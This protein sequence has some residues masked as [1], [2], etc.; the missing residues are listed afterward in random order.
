MDCSKTEVFFAE[1]KR[2]CRSYHTDKQAKEECK[3]HHIVENC[4]GCMGFIKNETSLAIKFVQE[5]SEQHPVKTR[6]SVFLEQYPNCAKWSDG[7]PKPCVGL[8]YGISG[9]VYNADG[10]KDCWKCWN[11]PIEGVQ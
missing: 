4:G 7:R 6:L 3:I 11:T 8:L 9:C 10:C 2:M 5:W 1:W